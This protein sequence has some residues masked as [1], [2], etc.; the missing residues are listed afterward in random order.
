MDIRPNTTVALYCRLSRDDENLQDGSNSDSIANQKKI[1]SKYAEDNNFRNTRFFVDDGWTGVN[2]DRP[3]FVELME[4]VRNGSIKTIIVKDHSRLGRNRLLVGTLLEEDFVQYD[5]RYI[6]ITDSIDTI[7]GLDD[8]LPMRDLFNEWHVKETSKKVKAVF[9]SKI[10][11]GEKL[12]NP[13]KYGYVVCGKS[14]VVDEETAPIVQRIF[15]LC[16]D[17][18]GPSQIA[19][20]LTEE[21]ITTPRAYN[22]QKTGAYGTAAVIN[23]PTLWAEQSI[24]GILEDRTYLGHT[25]VGKTVKPSY[26]SKMVKHLPQDQHKIFPNTHEQLVDEETFNLVQKIRANK[27]RPAKVGGIEPF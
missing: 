19:R 7:N 27:R 15:A 3:A 9:A 21:N 4:C 14:L 24:S 8:L 1:L 20:I 16:V 23:Y 11:R 10:S 5:V 25:V 17:G 13:S 26:K 12:G 6:A 18:F 2:F 22:Y